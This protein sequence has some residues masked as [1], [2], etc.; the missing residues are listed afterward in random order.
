MT[1]E[2]FRSITSATSAGLSFFFL[3]EEGVIVF[4]FEFSKRQESHMRESGIVKE[5]RPTFL[6]FSYAQNDAKGE[7]ACPPLDTETI[8]PPHQSSRLPSRLDFIEKG[9]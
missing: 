4:P 6:E 9:S 1:D 7:I 2:R 3:Q 8:S 5:A